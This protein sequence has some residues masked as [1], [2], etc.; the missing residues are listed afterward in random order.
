MK[1]CPECRKDYLDDSL[2]YCLDDGAALVQGS[3][4]DE[5]ATA[6]LSGNRASDEGL[7]RRIKADPRGPGAL[8]RTYGLPA[9]LSLERLPWIVAAALA[10][11]SAALAYA[12]L[13][14]S[15]EVGRTALRLSFEPPKELSFN[16]AQ[17][18]W[19]VISPD[20]E[21]IA[22]TANTADGKFGLYVSDLKSG[23]VT[24]IPGSDNALEPFWSPDSRSLAYGSRGKLKR[25]DVAG[26]S[27]QVLADAARLIAGAWNSNGDIVYC[28][29]YGAA[30]FTVSA[31][32]GEPR[33]V[34]FLEEGRDWQ[35]SGGTI[36][37]DGKRFLFNR[38]SADPTLAGLWMGSLDSSEIKK[39]TD[40]VTVRF[41]PPDW[42][43]MIRNQV[44]VAQRINTTTLDLIGE[45]IP[46]I[47]QTDNPISAPARF[48]V[49]SN[50]VLV[51]Q[52]RWERNYQLRLFDREGKQIGAIGNPG[53]I[54]A[55]QTP[56]VSP[57]G[58]QVAYRSANG[59]I[60]VS[61]LTG[62]NTIK[63]GTGQL[64]IWTPDGTRVAFHDT[65]TSD[66]RIVTRAASGVGDAETVLRGTVFGRRYSPDG[67]FLMFTKRGVK[68]RLDTYLL[69]LFDDR[70]ELP[71]LVTPA[72]EGHSEFSP[73]GR[74]LAYRS[75]ETGTDE[76]YVQSVNADG[77]L[78]G[79]RK[80]ISGE[81]G[82]FA[83]AWSRDGKELFYVARDRRMMTIPVKTDGPVFE[84]GAPKPL[85]ET[86][87]LFMYGGFDY[88][89]VTPDGNFLIGTLIGDP[90]APAPT[91][92]LNWPELVGK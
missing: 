46:I 66:R 1:R 90:S 32:G 78:G 15:P 29:D 83:L 69:Q 4:T 51:W 68:T 45:P 7:T 57:N 19:A 80:R 76:I 91:V 28:P 43:L 60:V 20:G 42:L 25:S 9:S 6:V 92:I 26:G 38:I 53:Y 47:T 75:D 34:T 39:I 27:P 59:D 31:K 82:A 87:P 22:F 23:Q 30:M 14:G 41:A 72:D 37:P 21:K 33:Q 64:P 55:A 18:D 49:S 13:N 63:L 61:D 12:Y 40:S 88:F 5:P 62:A 81:E 35:H 10:L 74:W 70:K 44:L 58:K 36:L 52:P 73:N 48:S 24:A 79:D 8:S 84:Y 67:R 2:L 56:Q 11:V 54:S 71:L 3:V 77:T 16:D 65:S 50:G 85:F 89:D 17:P 86:R